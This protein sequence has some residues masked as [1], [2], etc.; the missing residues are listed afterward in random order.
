MAGTLR[1]Q[2]TRPEFSALVKPGARAAIA[3]GSREIRDLF[4]VVETAVCFFKE[5]GA[6]PF[7]VSVILKKASIGFGAAIL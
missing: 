2:L 5:L 6:Q 3:V 7:I 1:A 4:T